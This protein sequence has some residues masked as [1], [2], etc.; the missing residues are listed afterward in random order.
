MNEPRCI[1]VG[2]IHG[3]WDEFVALLDACRRRP[4]DE[5]LTV[6]DMVDRG[7]DSE[8]VVRFFMTEPN[9]T[10]L[11][12]N[13]EDKHIRLFDCEAKLR[14]ARSQTIERLRL[15]EF[16]PEAVEWF[17]TL[18]LHAWRHG[19][20]ITHAGVVPDVA[21]EQQPRQALIRARMPW[22][23]SLFDSRH[24]PWWERY[25]G[26]VPILYGHSVSESVL[27]CG[28]TWGLDTGACFGGALSAVILPEFEIVTVPSNGDHWAGLQQAHRAKFGGPPG[29]TRKPRRDRVARPI[30]VAPRV[31][32]L[33]LGGDFLLSHFG[34]GK[35]DAGPWLGQTLALLD[36]AARAGRLVDEQALYALLADSAVVA[37]VPPARRPGDRGDGQSPT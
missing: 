32:D 19:C 29:A 14:P 36:D 2:D 10:A 33:E 11:L 13:H 25:A 1:V 24:V 26:E 7:P 20:F 22:M 18:P 9:A 31:G 8:R 21:L 28:Q 3:C 6:G 12:G 27:V 4:E 17:R 30:R 34:L 37:L 15:G 23:K 16:L 35:R 5:V